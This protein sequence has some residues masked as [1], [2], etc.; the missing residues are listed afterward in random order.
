MILV[1]VNFNKSSKCCNSFLHQS[2]CFRP[3]DNMIQH[4][5]ASILDF[6]EFQNFQNE[7][8]ATFLKNV[9]V[10]FENPFYIKVFLQNQKQIS[11]GTG[12]LAF[13][14]SNYFEISHNFHKIFYC[15]TNPVI[16][17]SKSKITAKQ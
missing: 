2:H 6:N 11:V 3:E 16:Q 4:R 7:M 17:F 1:F 14:T 5:E 10:D 12:E 15:F 9:V 8:N 13:K